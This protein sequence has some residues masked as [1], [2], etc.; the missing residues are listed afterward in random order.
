MRCGQVIKAAN[1]LSGDAEVEVELKVEMR[2]VGMILKSAQESLD[3]NGNKSED[4]EE[5]LMEKRLREEFRGKERVN[6]KN[7]NIDD[8]DQR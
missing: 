1:R 5:T 7:K 3:H 4:R 8:R 2:C 6:V